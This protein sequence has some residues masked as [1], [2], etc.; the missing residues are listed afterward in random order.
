MDEL[1]ESLELLQNEKILGFPLVM[2]GRKYWQ[3]LADFFDEMV[4][5]GTIDSSDL[6]LLLLTDSIDEAM[7][8]SEPMQLKSS[9]YTRARLRAGAGGC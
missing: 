9:A 6:N 4:K 7:P 5:L 2:M 8:I 3:P 1:F